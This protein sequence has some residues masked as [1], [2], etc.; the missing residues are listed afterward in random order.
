VKAFSRKSK[1]LREYKPWRYLAM[2]SYIVVL[3]FLGLTPF[4]HAVET[5]DCPGTSN[6][7]T[8]YSC[9]EYS[10]WYTEEPERICP[11]LGYGSCYLEGGG[12]FPVGN[13]VRKFSRKLPFSQV[14]FG[15]QKGG[16][17]VFC[18]ASGTFRSFNGGCV[19]QG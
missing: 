7:L 9:A 8:I 6:G 15:Y 13:P 16:H 18:T 10:Q 11:T 4:A 17:Y 19:P 3:V 12:A 14:D 1:L 5:T 2:K